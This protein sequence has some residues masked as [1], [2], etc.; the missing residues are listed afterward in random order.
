VR[1]NLF[2]VHTIKA[3][4]VVS[5]GYTYPWH[6]IEV[7]VQIYALVAISPQKKSSILLGKRVGPRTGMEFLDEESNRSR[8]CRLWNL[9]L[10]S[11]WPSLCT[12]YD[13]PAGKCDDQKFKKFYIMCY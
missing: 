6:L 9:G 12:D 1:A 3:Q 13:I 8:P 10:F 2:P 4:T 11:P 7:N 5:H